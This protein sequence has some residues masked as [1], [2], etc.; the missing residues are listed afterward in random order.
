MPNTI[1]QKVFFTST[2]TKDLYDLYM[3]S[4]KH[5]IATGARANISPKEGGRYSA[6][7]DYIKGKNLQS[8]KNKLIVQTWRAAG[9]DKMTLIR[10]LL[11]V[12]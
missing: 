11:F 1:C 2:K 9:W 8:V 7:D 6:H 10:R 12:S 5:S 3:D 4:K